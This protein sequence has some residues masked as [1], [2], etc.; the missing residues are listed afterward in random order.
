MLQ[1][2]INLGRTGF[3][4]MFRLDDVN[5][6]PGCGKSNWYVGRTTAECAFCGSALP[7][8]EASGAP[9]RGWARAA[10]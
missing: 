6:C 4:P 5:P 7:L 10:C 1:S 8:A 2:P 3:R 9:R